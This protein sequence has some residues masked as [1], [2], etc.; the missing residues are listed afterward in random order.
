MGT[1][2]W[3][4]CPSAR[5]LFAETFGNQFRKYI[6]QVKSCVSF[7]QEQQA[8]A[9][10]QA[11][12]WILPTGKRFSVKSATWNKTKIMDKQNK[13][14]HIGWGTMFKRGGGGPWTPPQ[15]SKFYIRYRTEATLLAEGRI[16][17]KYSLK[18][19][20]GC[21]Q[22][23]CSSGV[24]WVAELGGGASRGQGYLSGGQA[25]TRARWAEVISPLNSS[26]SWH[27]SDSLRCLLGVPIVFFNQRIII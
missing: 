3:L 7:H 16:L 18:Q 23:L 19:V 12:N 13:M 11:V 22:C 4:G 26:S 17:L 15:E 27:V 5:T 14:K 2:Q 21:W 9:T 24:A 10:V 25:Y 20:R 1:P 6:W 8:T